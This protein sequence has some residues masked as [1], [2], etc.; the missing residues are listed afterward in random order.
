MLVFKLDI[1][2]IPVLVMPIL[3][4]M[5]QM[6]LQVN[7]AL[8]LV[9]PLIMEQ[10]KVLLLWTYGIM[11][12]PTL[13]KQV[14]LL[15]LLIMALPQQ[16][17]THILIKVFLQKPQ[18]LVQLTYYA[19]ATLHQAQPIYTEYHKMTKPQVKEYNCET[20]E[21]IVRDATVAEI[22]QMAKDKAEADARQ[23]EAEAK[24]QAKATAEGKLAALGLTTDDLRAL[25]L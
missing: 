19:Q 25:G 8:M 12:I 1:I 4:Q 13:G 6:K 23:A 15:L 22:A 3:A 20:Q 18:Q 16:T 21:E 14:V 24:A 2:V 10:H 11:Q 9:L 5:Q 7:L 17:T